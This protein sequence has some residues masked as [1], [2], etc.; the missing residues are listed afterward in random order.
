MFS[1]IWF[2]SADMGFI[3][4]SN[5]KVFKTSNSGESWNDINSGTDKWLKSIFFVNESNGWI[6]GNDGVILK[7]LN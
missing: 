1:S 2:V 3:A 7:Y 4:G 6:V 5:G